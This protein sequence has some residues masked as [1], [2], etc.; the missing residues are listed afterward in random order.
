MAYTH[1]LFDFFGTL[2]DYS[3]SRVEQG[4]QTAHGILADAG[5]QLH[6]DAFLSTWDA[7]CETFDLRAAADCREYS[8]DT[9]CSSFLGEVLPATPPPAL[10]HRFRDAYLD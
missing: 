5:A 4:Y 1:L 2:V 8:M 9:L 3:A 6:Y 10:V 7:Y